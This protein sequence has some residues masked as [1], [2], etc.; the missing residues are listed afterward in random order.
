MGFAE[1]SG[2]SLVEDKNNPL[3]RSVF[4]LIRKNNFILL[5]KK[6]IGVHSVLVGSVFEK[7]C[8]K[9]E[10]KKSKAREKSKKID[11]VNVVMVQ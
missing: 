1:Y 11:A 3:M 7:L 10:K 9:N 6:P 4:F 5:G 2:A 8:I